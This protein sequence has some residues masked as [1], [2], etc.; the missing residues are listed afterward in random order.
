MGAFTNL[1]DSPMFQKQIHSL[2]Q[3]TEEL[4][5]RCQRLYKGCKKYMDVLGE[6]C[7]GDI[8]LADS[9]E[10][11]GGGKDDP[12]SVSI[13]GPVMSKFIATFRE[14]ATYKEL[15]RSQVE[16]VLIDRLTE[17]LSVD[18]QDAKDSRQ[19]FDK[20]INAY[21]QAREKF[22]SLKKSTREDIVAEQEEDL[23]NSKSAF[24]R[25]RFNL[26]NALMN[27][28]AKKKYEFLASFS[29]IMDAHLR[30]F[31]LG[32]D[33]LSELEPFIHQV[34]TYAQQSKELANVEKDNLAK[35]IQEFRTQTELDQFLA[36]GNVE[37]ST[38]AIGI[39]GVGMSSNKDIEAIMQSTAKGEV[40]T[41]KQGYLLKRSSSLRADWKRRFFVLDSHGTLYYHI[42]KG[43]KPAASPSMHSLSSMEHNSRVF[44]RFRL[45]HH[46][47]LS[48]GEETLG[49]RTVDL[50]TSTIKF[51]AE[52]ADL[53]LCFRIISPSKT[54]TL[55]AENE[56][57]RIDWMNKIT[58]VIASLL[59]SHLRQL[60][61]VRTGME[62][63]NNSGGFPFD[64]QSFDQREPSPDVMKGNE[65]ACA[66]RILREIPGND[67]CADCSA[68]E[69]DWAS[70]NL[71]ILICI[72]CSGV[73]RNLGVHISKVRSI[74]LDVKVWEPTILDLFQILGNA[75]CNSI[76]EEL[77]L[78]QNNT[79]NE[80]NALLPVTKPNPKEAFHQK[81]KYIQAKYVN[82]LL[83]NKAATGCGIP[84]QAASIWEAVKT[85]NV[86]EVYR[87]IVSSDE[88]I[89]NITYDEL[90]DA[91][92]RHDDDDDSLNGSHHVENKQH[93]PL[94]CKK[95]NDSSK[96]E[97]CLQGCSLLHLACHLGN[98]VM[99]ELLLQFGANMNRPDYHGRTPLHHCIAKR[100]YQ[101]AKFLLRRGAR[102]LIKD[103]GGLIPLE[104]AMEMGAIT[105]EELFILLADCK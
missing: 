1:D 20:A 90:T 8:M 49:C 91:S 31:K 12:V 9:L 18:L 96:P 81:E 104:R 101:L 89:T 54:Y 87:L 19:R 68:P 79:T 17:F 4:K 88:N 76:W 100:N 84:S 35:R 56:A 48:L 6:A 32:F 39:N 23:H 64:V 83:I 99:V 93:D 29:A 33:L 2:E 25:R 103:G 57:E 50:H 36:S 37:V 47:A 71:G 80:S 51:D 62:N 74:T 98:P 52:D 7:S 85:N 67:I 40:Q 70:L 78:L 43:S 46:R 10:D 27:V 3:N 28:E 42:N 21:D 82:K 92:L 44:G 55:Q 65:V 73:H 94:A 72:E 15:L 45:R 105:D 69:P 14:L 66:S 16:H 41:I 22:V 102:T 61:P 75:Y 24:E 26:V 38:S 34:L 53:R 63:K 95:I 77:L 59:N 5:E 97:S 11:F 13:G 86:R 58:G 60:P 30:Y